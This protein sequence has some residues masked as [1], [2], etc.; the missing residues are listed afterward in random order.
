MLV[1]GGGVGGGAILADG[2]VSSHLQKDSFLINVY[3]DWFFFFS[4]FLGG[5]VQGAG[6]GVGGH[7]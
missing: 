1:G 3:S 6:K 4:F 5:W 7:G 2:F